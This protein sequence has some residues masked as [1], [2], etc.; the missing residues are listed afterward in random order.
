MMRRLNN[1]NNVLNRKMYHCGTRPAVS[2][3][4]SRS[5]QPCHVRRDE[6]VVMT[7]RSFLL[8]LWPTGVTIQHFYH[9]HDPQVYWA[10]QWAIITSGTVECDKTVT[11]YSTQVHWP[12]ASARRGLGA[13]QHPHWKFPALQHPHLG[14]PVDVTQCTETVIWNGSRAWL[15]LHFLQQCNSV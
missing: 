2:S 4:D 5:S 10:V 1:N 6:D 3:T 7:A 14:P 9:R 11:P 15:Q 8:L 12:R 13:A